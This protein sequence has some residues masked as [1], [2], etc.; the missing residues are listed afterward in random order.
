MSGLQSTVIAQGDFSLN[1]QLEQSLHVSNSI[2]QKAVFKFQKLYESTEVLVSDLSAFCCALKQVCP[3]EPLLEAL[4]KLQHMFPQINIFL[5][6]II[7]SQDQ[8]KYTILINKDFENLSKSARLLQN[9][10]QMI[11]L[12]KEWTSQHYERFGEGESSDLI[13][14]LDVVMVDFLL[15]CTAAVKTFEDL[16]SLLREESTLLEEEA[17]EGFG[18]QSW[19]RQLSKT[20]L[21]TGALVSVPVVFVKL[22]NI[23]ALR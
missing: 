21:S 5:K 13:D 4:K 18:D 10:T 9:Y 15:D 19:W 7:V 20:V 8:Q 17:S 23:H 14:G 2:A 16:S 3:H 1:A 22:I 11:E 6:E 12:A